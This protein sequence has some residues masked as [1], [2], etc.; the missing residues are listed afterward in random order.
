MPQLDVSF[1]LSDPMLMSKFDV[2]RQT[3]SVGANG[4]AT[5]TPT[6][7]PDQHGVVTPADPDKLERGPDGSA[8]DEGPQRAH[9]VRAARRGPAG[10]APD[11]VIYAGDRYEVKRVMPWRFGQGWYTAHAETNAVQDPA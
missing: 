4:R 10:A 6:P 11:I 2:E 3:E 1:M 8:P 9:A 5:L 7:F